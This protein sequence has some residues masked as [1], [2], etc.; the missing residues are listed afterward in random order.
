M[1]LSND[2][3]L[4]GVIDPTGGTQIPRQLSDENDFNNT[5]IASGNIWAIAT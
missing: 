2:P 3:A 1:E 4:T 5:I